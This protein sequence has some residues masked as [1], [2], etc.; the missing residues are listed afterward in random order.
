MWNLNV[1]FIAIVLSAISVTDI[2]AYVEVYIPLQLQMDSM[3]FLPFS[4]R[5]HYKTNRKQ[6]IV[7]SVC[8]CV[9]SVYV[10]VCEPCDSVHPPFALALPLFF[11]SP[12]IRNPIKLF[13][14]P[15]SIRLCAWQLD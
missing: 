13:L 10:C 15:A 9:P 2:L 1:F 12:R 3:I 5:R 6:S 8:V 14:F 7:C 4:L 11:F